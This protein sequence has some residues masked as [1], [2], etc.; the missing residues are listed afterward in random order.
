M[1]DLHLP[2][3]KDD[4][5]KIRVGL[6][7]EGFPRALKAVAEISTYGARKYSPRGWEK[8]PQGVERYTDALGRH[9]LDELAGEMVDPESGRLHAAHLAW[10]ALARLELQLRENRGDLSKVIPRR[11]NAKG[12]FAQVYSRHE[13]HP[14][15]VRRYLKNNADLERNRM[16]IP[17]QES[18]TST[19]PG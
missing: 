18:Q 2:G 7:M 5:G 15:G 6:M 1:E 4:G 12:Q 14:E 9:L 8:V 16:G 3:A 11:R 17:S 10:N 13:R 19:Y